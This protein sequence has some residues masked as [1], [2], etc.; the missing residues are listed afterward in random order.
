MKRHLP[1]AATA[2][3]S[4]GSIATVAAA[5][6]AASSHPASHHASSAVSSLD[7]HWL[8]SS[9][10]TDLTEIEGGTTA[11]HKSSQ[12]T[13]LKLARTIV[14][15]HE[16]LL[17]GTAALAR[18]LGVT[19]PT[20]PSASQ[21]HTLNSVAEL[22]GTKFNI[23]FSRAQIAG[24]QTAATQTQLEIAHGSNALVKANA[25]KGLPMIEMH[26]TMAKQ[27]LSASEKG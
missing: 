6:A 5:P 16:T 10:Q 13:V 3:L 20:S 14:S 12:S 9:I 23:A 26:L 4:A 7:R 21:T 19:V 18:Q 2:L 15:Q 8:E 27:A 24:H 22:S 1:L 17:H 11:L 25:R